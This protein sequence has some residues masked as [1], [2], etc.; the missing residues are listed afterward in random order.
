MAAALIKGVQASTRLWS[1]RTLKNCFPFITLLNRRHGFIPHLLLRAR[2]PGAVGEYKAPLPTHTTLE[3]TVLKESE[4]L[5]TN[6]APLVWSYFPDVHLFSPNA[7]K[8]PRWHQ[9]F[10]WNNVQPVEIKALNC[11][12]KP[13]ENGLTFP[14]T[15]LIM[16][17]SDGEHPTRPPAPLAPSPCGKSQ[18]QDLKGAGGNVK[19]GC[20][21]AREWPAGRRSYGGEGGHWRQMSGR[22]T[23]T[24]VLLERTPTESFV[25][26]TSNIL[27]AREDYTHQEAEIWDDRWQTEVQQQ[28]S[29]QAPA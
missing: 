11:I 26:S 17:T 14:L 4:C 28:W 15:G 27:M 24:H 8:H 23:S 13:L 19:Y 7:A 21:D 20:S 3:K 1:S 22:M 29:R 9:W 10:N 18:W 2:L 12:S 25:G 6:D 5:L 16:C